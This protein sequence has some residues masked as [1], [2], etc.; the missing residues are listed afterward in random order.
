MSET[1]NPSRPAAGAGRDAFRTALGTLLGALLA[2]ALPEGTTVEIRGAL[3]VLVLAV[4]SPG[5]AALGKY[6][7]ARDLTTLF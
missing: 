5:L 1:R 4:V 2:S 3:V 7:R 6:M